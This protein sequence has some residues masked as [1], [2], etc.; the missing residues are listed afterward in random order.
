MRREQ[1]DGTVPAPSAQGLFPGES[2]EVE[3]HTTDYEQ[4]HQ[5]VVR[6]EAAEHDA[7]C[8]HPDAERCLFDLMR[9]MLGRAPR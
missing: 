2:H 5:F 7:I 1:G 6:G 3:E 8:H 9:H 4:R